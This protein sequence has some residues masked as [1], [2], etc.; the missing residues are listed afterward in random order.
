MTP[1]STRVP[2]CTPQH[3]QASAGQVSAE[4]ATT[5][6]DSAGPAGTS[7]NSTG[8]AGL[9]I[10][11]MDSGVGLVPTTVAIHREL[12]G[13]NL[14]VAMDPD[15]A[16]YGALTHD[17]LRVRA[18]AQANT[19]VAAGAQVIVVACNTAS[20]HALAHV[21]DVFEPAVPVIGTV[22]AVRP[23]SR[24]GR[25]FAVWATPATTAST[26]N[27]DLIA[28]FAADLPVYPIACPG[29]AQAID[30]ADPTAIDSAIRAAAHITPA[31]V[32]SIVL[33][34][35][36]YGLV[37][38]RIQQAFTQVNRQIALFDSPVAVAKQVAR[39]VGA[40]PARH[41]GEEAGEGATTSAK[42][43]ASTAT[44]EAGGQL[45]GVFLSGR[46]GQLPPQ[47]AAYPLGREL[48]SLAERA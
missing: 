29:L 7:D 6:G 3:S 5:R 24:T 11:V 26:Y 43:E 37:A 8:G 35:T 18:E 10:G 9:T 42:G 22:P 45:V 34:C 15:Y 31:E 2:G 20:V 30:H 27:T 1:P 17:E 4:R 12:P 19:L 16:P 13:A 38:A 44:G 25:P 21:R 48:A 33:G 41:P 39:R 36:H 32:E 47:V 23:A 14:L 40:H 28:Q 46:P